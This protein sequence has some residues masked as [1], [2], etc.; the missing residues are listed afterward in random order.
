MGR[1][2]KPKL[3]CQTLLHLPGG[4]NSQS[5]VRICKPL[6][7][8]AYQSTATRR[9]RALQITSIFPFQLGDAPG[10]LAFPARARTKAQPGALWEGTPCDPM[11]P[12]TLNL[13]SQG[14]PSLLPPLRPSLPSTSPRYPAPRS[15]LSP[16]HSSFT[17]RALFP[18]HPGRASSSAPP[19]AL[20]ALSAPGRTSSS[21]VRSTS[22]GTPCPSRTQQPGLRC[23]TFAELRDPEA[24]P[25]Q[26]PSG[27]RALH[28]PV[29]RTRPRRSG[30]VAESRVAGAAP[31][32]S[33]RPRPDREFRKTSSRSVTVT[34]F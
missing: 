2:E 22:R 7:L 9:R 3:S 33:G 26:E 10:T 30:V 13:D 15:P 18:G 32:G 28:D 11:V 16:T 23:L 4:Q 1:R 24:E 21:P 8:V 19:A 27:H 6:I 12:G 25:D 5:R 34:N 29:S 31:Q 20:A 14:L 17:L